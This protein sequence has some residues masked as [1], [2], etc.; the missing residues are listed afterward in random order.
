MPINLNVDMKKNP[1]IKTPDNVNKE[2]KKFNKKWF[3][4]LFLFGIIALALVGYRAL[5]FSNN[6]GIK[7]RP[8][9]LINPIKKDPELKR[10]STGKYTSALL[11]GIDSRSPKSGLLN[12]DSMIIATY[13]YDTHNITMI[14]VPRDLYVKLPDGGW[15]TKINAFYGHGE[16]IKKGTGMEYLKKTLTNLTGIEIQYYAL[17]DL[18]G[19]KK[20]IDAVGGVTVNVENTF[21]DYMYPT[22]SKSKPVYETVTFKK[23][24]QTMDGTTALKYA[25][26]RHSPDYQEGTDF[27]RAKRQQKVISALKDKVLTSETLL[28]PQKVLDIMQAVQDNVKLSEITT[29]D[30]QA[31]INIAK[32]LQKEPGKNYSF[33]LEPSFGNYQVLT[34]KVPGT[35][36]YVIAPIA[37][38]DNYSQVKALVKLCITKP[39]MYSEKSI[40][41]IYDIGLGNELATKK[42]N[43]IKKKYPFVDIVY[44]GKLFSG[45]T[46]TYVYQNTGKTKGTVDELASYLK[47]ENKTKPEY[48]TTNLNAEN[49]TILLGKEEVKTE[50]TQ[51]TDSIQT[52]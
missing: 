9:D 14:S 40:V 41:R 31:G 18:Q 26:S 44:M 8:D 38:L 7:I 10:D 2:K 4:L 20:M 49:V 30:I 46:G 50:T 29:D 3:G 45:K 6:V 51:P 28:N 42:A 24:V 17:V 27:A 22:E 5:E 21:T 34:T 36:A 52:N 13:N 35:N 19:F 16:G 48:I 15:Y 32:I 37:G 1:A 33:V 23:G 25:R 43:E 39:A 12:T 47:V 11:V